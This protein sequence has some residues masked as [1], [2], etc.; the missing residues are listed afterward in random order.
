MRLGRRRA[1][2]Y[3]RASKGKPPLGFSASTQ[4]AG[5]STVEEFEVRWPLGKLLNQM[6]QRQDR[7]EFNNIQPILERSRHAR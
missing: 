2:M 6:E 1:W 3:G 7:F 4:Y 5:C